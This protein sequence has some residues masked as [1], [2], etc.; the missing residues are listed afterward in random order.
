MEK[1]VD[2]LS[3]M[4]LSNHFT[5]VIWGLYDD[6]LCSGYQTRCENC[7]DKNSHEHPV[8][9]Y[10]VSGPPEVN[11]QTCDASSAER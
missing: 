11:D 6:M 8:S 4:V 10:E 9:E 7:H 2:V 3:V 1:S 5:A